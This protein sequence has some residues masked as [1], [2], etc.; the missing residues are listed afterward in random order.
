[1]DGG[2]GES[3]LERQQN[4]AKPFLIS[5]RTEGAEEDLIW[6]MWKER[7][8]LSTYLISRALPNARRLRMILCGVGKVSAT[9]KGDLSGR[10]FGRGTSSE[11]LVDTVRPLTVSY[12]LQ[13]QTALATRR[14]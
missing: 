5:L 2:S 3:K 6:A 4:A 10:I 8:A 13:V 7:P 12:G 14:E 11:S 1:M 9:M